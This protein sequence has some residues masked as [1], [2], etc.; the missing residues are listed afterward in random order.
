MI[1]TLDACIFVFLIV[2]YVM[3]TKLLLFVIVYPIGS[4]E[5]Y[6]QMPCIVRM[7]IQ[8]NIG[9]EMCTG[10]NIYSPAVA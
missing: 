2:V 6:E 9:H 4:I 10:N 1:I 5:L 8:S 7:Y 3:S